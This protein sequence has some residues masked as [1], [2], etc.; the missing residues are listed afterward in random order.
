V[1][2]LL[3]ASLAHRRPGAE[4]CLSLVA[5]QQQSQLSVLSDTHCGTMLMPWL[6]KQCTDQ[7]AT[8]ALTCHLSL[9]CAVQSSLPTLCTTPAKA[10]SSYHLMA[11]ETK[12]VMWSALA[13]LAVAA[14]AALSHPTAAEKAQVQ[15]ETMRPVT[16][17]NSGSVI[18]R[19]ESRC[20]THHGQVRGSLYR[21][22][23]FMRRCLGQRLIECSLEATFVVQLPHSQD[24]CRR[25]RCASSLGMIMPAVYNESVNGM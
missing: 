18:C 20:N 22:I 13:A 10:P 9:V 24:K 15:Q 4:L 7:P 23:A 8:G 1:C 17:R 16:Q 2:A 12:V 6:A 14:A 21:A 25:P 11:R 5:K 3:L 19:P